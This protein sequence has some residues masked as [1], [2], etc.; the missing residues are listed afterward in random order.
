MASWVRRLPVRVQNRGSLTVPCRSWSQTWSAVAVVGVN[1][2]ARWVFAALSFAYQVRPG[3]EMDIS[4]VECGEFGDT[5]PGVDS[6]VDEGAGR[7][8]LPRCCGRAL[9]R[10][11]ASISSSWRNVMVLLSVIFCGMART[12][13]MTAVC[14][15]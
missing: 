13:W 5:E 12:L 4:A 6:E 2:T 3:A 11:S 15:G 7:A 8:V 9:G 1:G 10:T 14:L